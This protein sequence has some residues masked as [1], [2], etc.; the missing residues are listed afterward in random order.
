MHRVKSELCAGS[1][2]HIDLAK[3][4]DLD[5][6]ELCQSLEI[7]GVTPSVGMI[8]YALDKG[9]ETH[10]LIRPRAGDFYYSELEKELMLKDVE[11]CIKLGVHGVV[12]GA[13]NHYGELDY[14]FIQSV[15][16]RVGFLPITIHRVVDT[17]EN[18]SSLQNL[19]YT[20]VQRI[21]TSG[22][23]KCAVEGIEQIKRIKELIPDIEVMPGGGVNADNTQKIARETSATSIH[24]SGTDAVLSG[25]GTMYES[26]LLIPNAEK[27]KAI[28]RE[29]NSI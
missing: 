26:K 18:I 2:E 8:Q 16:N 19:N 12:V 7:G 4:L 5:R 29:L 11:Q 27:I 6:I 25:Q 22:G 14:D 24:F 17:I 15:E 20:K 23:E 10:V 9:V 1:I 13:V 28:L 3:K 21:L